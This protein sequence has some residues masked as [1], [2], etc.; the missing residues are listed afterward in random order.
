MDHECRGRSLVVV[1]VVVRG[2]RGLFSPLLRYDNKLPLSLLVFLS[3]GGGGW[4]GV[5][6][7]RVWLLGTSACRLLESGQHTALAVIQLFIFLRF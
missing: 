5:V 2:A 1:V 4:G 7:R 3:C 6:T